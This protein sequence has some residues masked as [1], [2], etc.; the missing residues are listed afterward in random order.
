MYAIIGNNFRAEMEIKM[1]KTTVDEVAS[2]I[3]ADFKD[4]KEPSTK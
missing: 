1:G 2:D 3:Q 4:E